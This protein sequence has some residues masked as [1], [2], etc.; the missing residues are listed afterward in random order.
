MAESDPSI[1][2]TDIPSE[3]QPGNRFTIPFTVSQGPQGPS[4]DDQGY[5]VDGANPFNWNTPVT[6]WVDG[7]KIDDEVL[8]VGAGNEKSGRFSASLSSGS[9][10][11]AVKVHPVGQHGLFQTWR[12]NLDV[13]NDEVSTT[14]SVST[15]ARDPSRDS[16]QSS[17]RQFLEDL[18]GQLGTTVN[19]IALGAAIAVAVF[20][21]I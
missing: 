6:L 21:V 2:S 13:V 8:C 4:L 10:R 5:C 11:V 18:A 7:E 12:D 9:H 14:V 17:I 15:D 3:A 16:D 1:V 19:M 20:L